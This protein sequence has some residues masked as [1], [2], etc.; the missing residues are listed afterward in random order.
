MPPAAD[1]VADVMQNRGVF[2]QFSVFAGQPV[3]RFQFHEQRSR[4]TF[5]LM[6]VA[7]VIVVAAGEFENG[8]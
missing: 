6:R 8:V 3:Q 2:Q 5:H 4:Q 7:G 1:V